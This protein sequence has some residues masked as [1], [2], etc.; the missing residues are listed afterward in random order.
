MTRLSYILLPR[1]NT[2]SAA[3]LDQSLAVL[4]ECGYQ[5]VEFNLT[6]PTGI[7]L[8]ELERLTQRHKLAVPSFLTGEA[9]AEGLCLCSPNPEVRRQTIQRLIHYLDAA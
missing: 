2:C 9:Y 8:D 3:E 1:L 4:C 6:E 7:S 5:G